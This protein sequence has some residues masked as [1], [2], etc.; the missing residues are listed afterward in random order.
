MQKTEKLKRLKDIGAISKEKEE[1]FRSQYNRI[2]V[3]S[4]DEG[5]LLEILDI[6]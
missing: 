1:T 2:F 4:Y 3:D 6:T 5:R